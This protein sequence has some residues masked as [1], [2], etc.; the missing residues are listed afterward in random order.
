MCATISENKEF[1]ATHEIYGAGKTR[2]VQQLFVCMF[3]AR[4][5]HLVEGNLIE[6]SRINI[7]NI[8]HVN[9]KC[10]EFTPILK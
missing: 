2:Y 8:N 5:K 10:R 1:C 6:N 7:D 9:H 3:N 4:Y